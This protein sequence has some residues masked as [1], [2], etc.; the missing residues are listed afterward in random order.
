MLGKKKLA[1]AI[2]MD[3]MRAF[4]HVSKTSLVKRMIKL[5]IDGDLIRWTQFFLTDRKV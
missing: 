1:A 4:D 2:F 3:V 5:G